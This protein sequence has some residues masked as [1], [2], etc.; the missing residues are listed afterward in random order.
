MVDFCKADHMYTPLDDFWATVH[1][2][3]S[4]VNTWLNSLLLNSL[5]NMI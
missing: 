3:H 2:M 4:I 1:T 5:D